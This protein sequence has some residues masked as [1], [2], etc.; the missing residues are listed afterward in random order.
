MND[1]DMAKRKEQEAEA[2]FV[3]IEKAV[4]DYCVWCEEEN[5][6]GCACETDDCPL[7]PYSK[8]RKEEAL[9]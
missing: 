6:C 3:A 9:K 1:T 7:K 4:R 2:R 8:A 5:K